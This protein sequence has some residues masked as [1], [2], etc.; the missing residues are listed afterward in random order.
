MQTAYNL[1]HSDPD[2]YTFSNEFLR[3]YEGYKKSDKT[4]DFLDSRIFKVYEYLIENGF[5]GHKTSTI[6]YTYMIS[7]IIN[8]L[9]DSNI[10]ESVTKPY[11]QFYLNLARGV[12]GIGAST[13]HSNLLDRNYQGTEI[14]KLATHTYG[15]V[16]LELARGFVEKRKVLVK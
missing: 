3:F 10:E 14:D 7:E 8:H 5:E 12:L 16:A 9:N 1:H 15:S 2:A 6:L 4:L 13:F 11:S